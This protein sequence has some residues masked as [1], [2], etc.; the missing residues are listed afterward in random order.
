MAEYRESIL[1]YIQVSK[2]VL[3][4]GELTDHEKDAVQAILY[5]LA[6]MLRLV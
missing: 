5:R 1:E 4:A 2:L 6:E 3:E